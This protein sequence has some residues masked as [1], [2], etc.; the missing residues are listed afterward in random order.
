MQIPDTA[1]KWL[2]QNRRFISPALACAV[3]GAVSWAFWACKVYRPAAF[4]L[5]FLA[6]FAL[7]LHGFGQKPGRGALM[8]CAGFSLAVWLIL[9]GLHVT[10]SGLVRFGFPFL[11][12][13]LAAAALWL[14]IFWGLC[15]FLRDLRLPCAVPSRRRPLLEFLP[16]WLVIL[17]AWFPVYL[18]WGPVRLDVDSVS[19]LQQALEGG[20]ND[21]Q[22]VFYTL[23]LRLV[24][25][26][27]AALGLVELGAYLFGA[28]QMA[29][30]AAALAVN[31]V[32][33][34]RRGCGP[35]G[36]LAG[37]ALFCLTT[38]YAFQS[39]VVWKDPLFNAALLLYCLMLYDLAASRGE[40]LSTR[41][42]GVRFLLLTLAI[43]LLR[44]NGWLIALGAGLALLVFPGARRWLLV[45]LLPL[46]LAVKLLTGP[47]YDLLGIGSQL[48]AEAW[49]LPL[50]QVGYVLQNGGQLTETQAQ[51]LGRIIPPDTLVELYDPIVVDPIKRS[52]DFNGTYFSTWQGK[53]DL[54]VVWLQLAPRHMAGYFNAWLAVTRGYVDPRYDAGVYSFPYDEQN[55]SYGVVYH[56][57]VGSLTGWRGLRGELEIRATFFAPGLLAFGLLFC[58]I[59]LWAKGAG[60]YILGFLPMLLVW[61]GL[62]IGSPSYFQ[63]RYML[64]YAYAVPA[65]IFMTLAA[66]STTRFSADPSQLSCNAGPSVL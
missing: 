15:R 16:C 23:L 10:G 40:L 61:A 50:Q 57:L 49:S 27:F 46:L 20:L 38:A 9:L 47:V 11:L 34:R 19:L 63:F 32:W 4:V 24:L 3:G 12:L 30:V 22:P 45:H 21:A 37:L 64:V 33:M 42:V 51:R 65:A 54:L 1:R 26:P 48:T 62:L 43:C 2:L 25:K 59:V 55:G 13:W 18:C 29:V 5:L 7:S 60:R 6:C 52:S 36:L 35:W 66:P 14:P 31:L 44:G 58:C 28:F 8:L 39:L 41:G 17:A 53:R 56:D